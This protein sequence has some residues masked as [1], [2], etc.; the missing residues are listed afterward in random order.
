MLH[1]TCIL[2]W[3]NLYYIQCNEI[4]SDLSKLKCI[5]MKIKSIIHG[6]NI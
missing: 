1:N 4:L 5:H 6:V 3:V 2:L